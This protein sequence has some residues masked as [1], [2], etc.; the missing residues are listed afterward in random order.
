MNYT[1]GDFFTNPFGVDVMI[2]KIFSQKKLAKKLPF[3]T[4]SKAK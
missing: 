1:L 3:L 2:L 4:P